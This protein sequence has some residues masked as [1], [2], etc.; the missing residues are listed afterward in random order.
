MLTLPLHLNLK[1]AGCALFCNNDSQQGRPP[2]RSLARVRARAHACLLKTQ[3]PVC[4]SAACAAGCAAPQMPAVSGGETRLLLGRSCGQ[5]PPV[6]NQL[7]ALPRL[8]C[9]GH[10]SVVWSG[11]CEYYATYLAAAAGQLQA[12]AN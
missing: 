12:I 4:L 9:S 11:L 2:A 3:P 7:G 10:C 6:Q 1:M 8:I 5:R